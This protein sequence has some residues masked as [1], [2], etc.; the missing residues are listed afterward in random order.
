MYSKFIF[1][2]NKKQYIIPYFIA[3]HPGTTLM[4]MY[5][6]SM[7]LKKNYLKVQQVQSYIPIP[8]TLSEAMYYTELDVFSLKKMH[9]AKNEERLLQRVLLQPHIKKNHQLLR[10]ALK[11]IGKEN[12]FSFLTRG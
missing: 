1:S 2:N 12:M 5:Q 9:V 11:E 8:L 7:Y 4:D 3:G 10:K 6:L